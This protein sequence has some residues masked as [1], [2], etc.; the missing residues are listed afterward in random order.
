MASNK[1]KPTDAASKK[2]PCASTPE[3]DIASEVRRS[4]RLQGVEATGSS[5]PTGGRQRKQAASFEEK[6]AAVLQMLV[7]LS[8]EERQKLISLVSGVRV[9]PLTD[10]SD[11]SHAHVDV[12]SAVLSAASS[13]TPP[14]AS[15]APSPTSRPVAASPSYAAVS[16]GASSPLPAASNAPPKSLCPA[17]VPSLSSTSPP[18]TH[19]AEADTPFSVVF[20]KK[21]QRALREAS[22]ANT[23]ARSPFP[24]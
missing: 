2:A 8:P 10:V 24:L 3:L 20:S 17:W 9:S 7:G 11:T 14:V 1:N 5:L 6:S 12:A 21:N 23:H 15:P 4:A 18:A 19:H 13:S 22:T 16:A